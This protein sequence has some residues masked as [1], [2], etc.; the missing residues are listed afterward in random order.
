MSVILAG[1]DLRLTGGVDVTDLKKP[2][3]DLQLVAHQALV[4]RTDQYSARADGTI[5]AKGGMDNAVISGRAE[6]VRGR[7][8]KEIEFLPLSLPG[9]RLP[10]PP[11]AVTA[12]KPPSLPP[13][14]SGWT[15]DVDIVTRDPIRLLGNVMSGSATSNLKFSGTGAAPSLVGEVGFDGARVRLPNSRLTVSRGKLIFTQ[16]KPFEPD[17][18]VQAESLVSNYEVTVTAYGSAFKPKVRFTSSPPLPENQVALL[19][20]TGSSEG[21]ESAIAGAAANTAAF[22]VLKKAYRSVFDKAA[23]KR[24]DDDPPRLTFNFSPLTQGVTATYH[25]N[26]HVQATGGTTERGTFRGMLYYMV[27]MR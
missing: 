4:V 7:V 11:P 20:A 6:L 3:V 21:G 17:I 25:I 8:F 26:E 23:P 27:R 15:F 19:L 18:D 16:D 13:P 14:M 2:T 5:T 12:R 1:G 9:E 22:E 24:Y 10:P